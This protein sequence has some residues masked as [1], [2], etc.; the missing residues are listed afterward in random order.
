[1]TVTLVFFALIIIYAAL[2]F[3]VELHKFQQNSYRNERFWKFLKGGDLTSGVRIGEYA[4]MILAA[5]GV[6]LHEILFF[7]P[8][9]LT[10]LYYVYYNKTYKPKVKFNFTS[11]AKRLYFTTVALFFIFGGL[12]FMLTKSEIAALFTVLCCT[13]L[14]FCVLMLANIVLKPVEKKINNWYINDAKRILS[15]HKDLIIVG[16][17]GSY[18]K[19]ST[20]HFLE[21]I[22]SEKYNV[23]MTPGSFNTTMGVV[24]TIREYL[25]P[26]HQV[27][28]CEMGAKQI[29]D[30]KEICDIV[31]PRVGI[32]TS[33]AEQHLDTFKTLE[34]VRKTKFE[35]IDSLP[36]EGLA[37]LN[38]DY[39]IIRNS[40]VSKPKE[41]FSTSDSTADYNA[42]NI[43][44]SPKG[45]EFEIYH[46]SEKIG[47]FTTPLLGSYNISNIVSAVVCALK[48]GLTIEQIKFGV[49]KLQAVEHRME[50][51]AGP[52][53][54]VLIDDAFN[55]NPKGAKMALEI[56]SQFTDC[57]KFVITPGIIELADRQDFYNS[58]FGK[59]IAKAAD[60]AVLVG[61]E[62]TKAIYAGLKAENYPED[63]IYI[64][65]G[66]QDAANFAYSKAVS[67]D[68]ILFENDLPDY[69]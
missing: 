17:T 45:T 42:K 8:V 55:S 32:L 35:L 46:F 23:L 68:V 62:Q 24:R 26:T 6:W 11:R 5:L 27:F 44:F 21:K 47:D 41:Y 60:F 53:G 22:L 65:Q 48:L 38:G 63:K 37:I 12:G 50:I 36:Q 33:V 51:K 28:I 39:E 64:A 34:N 18:G 16:I 9:L 43:K 66:L 59:Q 58:E 56:L 61:K 19:T 7:S 49:H 69:H 57:Q 67:G 40:A 15:E 2:K 1:M 13:V 10:M 30:I 14:S 31:H 52:N 4:A 3:K 54:V 20:K 25:Q 29:N